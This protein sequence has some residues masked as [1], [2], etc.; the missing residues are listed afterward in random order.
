MTPA[1]EQDPRVAIVKEWVFDA[2]GGEAERQL[3]M[4]EDDPDSIPN[5]LAKLDAAQPAVTTPDVTIV[6]YRYRIRGTEDWSLTITSPTHQG[7]LEVQALALYEDYVAAVLAQAARIV[8]PTVDRE[9]TGMSPTAEIMNMRLDAAAL[10]A[11][12]PTYYKLPTTPEDEASAF[13]MNNPAVSDDLIPFVAAP[14]EP[15]D[16]WEITEEDWQAAMKELEQPTFRS[17]E[18]VSRMMKW[19]RDRLRARLTAPLSSE[20]RK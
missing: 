20:E 4:D 14:V 9:A 2:C 10:P 12:V 11:P 8:A 17:D 18:R 13:T 15:G 3:T 19:M 16:P 1:S 6:G 7:D 5:F